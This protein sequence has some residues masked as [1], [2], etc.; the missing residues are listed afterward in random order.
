L[1]NR[2]RW[3]ATGFAWPQ[4]A[5]DVPPLLAICFE[6]EEAARAI[7]QSWK[8]K[9]GETDEKE[10]LRVSIITGVDEGNPFSYKVVASTELNVRDERGR[11]FSMV[12]RINRMDPPSSRNL[13]GFL[14]R[15]D[16]V[17]WYI[18]AP[19]RYI[20]DSTA[21]IFFPELGILKRVLHCRPAWQIGGND[22]DICALQSDD[23]P[24]IPDGIADAPVIKALGRLRN[25]DQQRKR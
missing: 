15:F 11:R 4:D 12:A 22:P 14:R 7:F 17:K 16:L 1:W 18:I 10:E 2:A 3:K 6:N 20:D 19:G 5:I 8:K 25:L 9:L 23:Q 13:D 21:P 24:I